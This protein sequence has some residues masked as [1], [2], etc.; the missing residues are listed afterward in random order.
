[1]LGQICQFLRNWFDTDSRHNR[2]PFW[3][4]EITIESGELV[5]FSDRLLDGQYFRIVD[6]SLNDGVYQYPASGLKDE[7]FVGTVQSMKIP[8]EVVA[9]AEDIESWISANQA[10]INSPY[11]SESFGGYSYSLKSSNAAGGDSGGPTW[12]SQ[13]AARL[14]PYRKI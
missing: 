8:P 1:M 6:S 5:G 3:E 14:G 2:L 12:Q 11:Q 4:E 10:A 9:I 13:F 7:T